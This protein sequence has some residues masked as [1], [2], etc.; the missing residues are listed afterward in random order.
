MKATVI[1]PQSEYYLAHV[2]A[3][4]ADVDA[5]KF[6]I[7]CQLNGAEFRFAQHALAFC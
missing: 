4:Q 1:N 2:I 6:W 5:D 3:S 7:R